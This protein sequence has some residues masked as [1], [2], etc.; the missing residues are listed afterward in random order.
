MQTSSSTQ[1]EQQPDTTPQSR[2]ARLRSFLNFLLLTVIFSIA[3]AQSPMYTSNQNQYFL[4]GLA[5]AGFGY[6]NQDW[7]A[8]TPDPT[9][10]FSALV[11]LTYRLTHLSALFY[12]YYALL[13]GIYI[14]SLLGIVTSI[15]SL[16]S[17]RAKFF[18]FLAL[19]ILVHSAAWRFAI[20]RSLGVN[21][22]YILE[23]GL[24]DQ[25][26]L[27]PVFEPSVFAALLML[28]IYL[29]MQRKPYLAVISAALAATVHPTYLLSAAV[30]TL[31]Y[32]LIT[33]IETGIFDKRLITPVLTNQFTPRFQNQLQAAPDT[34]PSKKERPWMKSLWIGALALLVVAPILIYVY[35]NFGNT[36]PETTAR[37]QD[38]LVNFR[39]P[40]HALI[41]WWWD[42]TAV[43]KI[44]LVAAALFLIR[45]KRLFLVM[46]LLTLAAAGLTLLQV[47]L[48]SNMLALLFPWRISIILVPLATA[49]LLAD[50]VS[51]SFKHL[52]LFR[53]RRFQNFLAASS[54][55]LIAAVVLVGG[56]RFSLDLQRKASAVERPLEAYV[57]SH[58]ASGQV[59][60]TPI[61]L[62]DFRL[63]TGS[64]V[65]IEFKSIPYQDANVLEWYRRIQL[66]DRFYKNGDCKLLN[67]MATQ[68]GV[69]HIVMENGDPGQ[70]CPN[71]LPIYNDAYYSLYSL[72]SP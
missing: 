15:Y 68:S 33:A 48:K 53:Q 60:L 22:T 47:F 31:S 11:A 42:A 52:R 9:P 2:K 17:S 63:E 57:A 12:I 71:L 56:I 43:V 64:P 14:F 28:S 1:F 27:G 45:K 41:S 10:V 5:Q 3:Y 8:N 55:L 50:L 25:R 4:H 66:A 59:Y 38:I 18:G 46:L 49:I 7:L 16:R 24:A 69:T 70:N 54:L 34:P 30:L 6:L 21:W 35:V 65:Y 40:H 29:F 51:A 19:L 67:E 32:M 58:H 72:Q 36:P 39:I 13:M 62:Q 23:D 44:L 26:L 61:K 20:S 37:A